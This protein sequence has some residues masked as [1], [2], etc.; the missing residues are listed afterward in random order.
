MS[1]VCLLVAAGRG[2]RAKSKIPKQYVEI[3]GK[4]VLRHSINAILSSKKID[5]VLVVIHP[6]DIGLYK[7]AISGLID[8]RLVPPVHGGA[9]RSASVR[10]G[11]DAITEFD[12]DTV[13]IHDAARPFVMPE[14]IDQLVEAVTPT[15]GAFLAVPV[16]D[17]IWKVVENLSPIDREGL[18]R[19]QTPQAFPYGAIVEAFQSVSGSAAD[20]VA[21]AVSAGLD[22]VPIQSTEKNFKITGPEDF[23]RAQNEL[24]QA[25]DIRTGN[26]FDVHAFTE[27]DHVILNGIKIPHNK[28]L[29]GHSDADVAMHAITDALFGGLCEGDIGQWFPPSEVEWKGAASE[30][31]LAKAVERVAERGFTITHIDC[32]IICEEPKIGPHAAA[33]REN[34]SRI[35]KVDVDRISV[36]ATTS[37]QLGFTGRKEGIAAL[38]SATLVAS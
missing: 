34:I 23:A 33:M 27:G 22:V 11:L 20:D 12:C 5:H 32:T 10:A 29:S 7:T 26:A 18:W 14:Q 24:E 21:I 17:A 19:A 38:A 37:E 31:F 28:A 8:P 16:V 36:K 6:D 4:A 9:D 30:I 3:A 35:C 1:V 13:L 2:T 25:L 15:E